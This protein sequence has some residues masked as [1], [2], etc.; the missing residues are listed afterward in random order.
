MCGRFAQVVKH[1]QLKKMIDE[2]N[3]RNNDEQ[4]EINYNVAP[5]QAIAAV[6]YKR[7][8]RFL[9]F[10]RWGLIPSWSKEPSTQYSMINVRAESILEKKTFK[11]ALLRRRCLIPAN[12]FYEWRKPD[13]QPFFIYAAKSSVGFQSCEKDGLAALESYSTN[14]DLLFFAG[15]TEYWTSADGSYIQSAAI[16]T[17]AANEL[18]QPIHDRMPVILPPEVWKSWLTD[19]FQDPA[20]LQAF[21]KP[22][23]NDILTAYPVSRLVNT[24]N[25]NSE[26]CYK[27]LA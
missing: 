5:T 2:L 16:I 14:Y 25:F 17:T 9:T 18:M 8:E 3:I 1:D 19:S 24:V 13:K 11:N 26:E 12:G 6:M 21:L 27:P 20:S 10:F 4:I 15:I 7:E 23:A 22:C